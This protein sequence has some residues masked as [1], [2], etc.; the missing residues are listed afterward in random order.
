MQKVPD[1]DPE[2]EAKQYLQRHCV[3]PI[4]KFLKDGDILHVAVSSRAKHQRGLDE[5]TKLTYER[6]SK[7][8]T[9]E[10]NTVSPVPFAAAGAQRVEPG[11]KIESSIKLGKQRYW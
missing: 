6:V 10:P 4:Q 3:E 8:F 2:A 11:V 5:L 9:S 1:R 7:S